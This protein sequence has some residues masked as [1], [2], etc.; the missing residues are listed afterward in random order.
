[1]L[2]RIWHDPVWSKVIAAILFAALT[3]LAGIAWAPVRT[4]VLATSPIPNWL[5]ALLALIIIV[6]GAIL[7]APRPKAQA[8]ISAIGD[9]VIGED[10]VP[11]R[12][13]PLKVYQVMRNDSTES[14]DVAVADYKPRTVTL[15]QF[16]TGV[17][18]VKLRE[19]YP[20]KEGVDRLAV[21]PGQQFKIWVGVD[22]GKFTKD[23]LERLRGK[24]GTMVLKVNHHLVHIEL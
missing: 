17:L 22:E 20:D 14:A 15:K 5:T 6:Q 9:A 13:F 18:Q 23:Q 4:F 10:K 2:K 3:G 8:R 19:W 7:F 24:I 21:L 1:M 16:V 12:G 11:G